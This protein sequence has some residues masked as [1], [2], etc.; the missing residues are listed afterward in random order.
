MV[1]KAI[2]LTGSSCSGKTTYAKYLE[3]TEG[4]KYINFDSLY[5][6]A[7]PRSLNYNFNKLKTA[8]KGSEKIILDGYWSWRDNNFKLFKEEICNDVQN[9]VTIV[10]IN[11]LAKRRT[12]RYE[13]FNSDEPIQEVN[14]YI[15]DLPQRISFKDSEFINTSDNTFKRVIINSPEQLNEYLIK[16]NKKD[17]KN[18]LDTLTYDKLYGDIKCIN[19]KGYSQSEKSW[20][21]IKDLV[22]WWGKHVIELGCF[23]GY[24]SFQINK[25][26]TV[27][28]GLDCNENIINTTK[29]INWLEESHVSF[30]C[31]TGGED[32]PCCD[33]ILCMNVLHHFKGKQELVLSKMDCKQVI[34]EIN[35]E[36][37]PL[38]SK[39]FKIIKEVKSHRPN[40]TILLGE[41]I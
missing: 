18:Y 40:R 41:R 9:I 30:K 14:Y 36:E 2:I 15:N 10:T 37:I 7:K 27:V 8:V 20:E 29:F 26:D 23:H 28:T 17:F 38:I 6:Y 11:E 34:F 33:I 3:K 4:Y 13:K 5:N 22:D 21:S 25:Q 32:I 12:A 19:F 1:E 31:W 16:I 39:Y 24:F 35:K